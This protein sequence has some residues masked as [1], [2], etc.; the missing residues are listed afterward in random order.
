MEAA[1]LADETKGTVAVLVT[2][3]QAVTGDEPEAGAA[4][5]SGLVAV[6]GDEFVKSVT[7]G[8]RVSKVRRFEHLPV[9]A[10]TVDAASSLEVASL[11]GLGSGQVNS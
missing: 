2:G 1:R 6:T 11:D 5:G 10:M 4:A 3:W 8:G 9:I 7:G